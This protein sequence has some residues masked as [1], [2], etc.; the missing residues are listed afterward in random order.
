[1]AN[2]SSADECVILVTGITGSGKSSFI[3]LLSDQDVAV[4]HGLK[5]GEKS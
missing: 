3:K 5:A 2:S 4:G 1:M